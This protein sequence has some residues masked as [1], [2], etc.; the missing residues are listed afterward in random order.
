TGS[1]TLAEVSPGEEAVVRAVRDDDSDGLL[2]VEAAGLL[3]GAR[4]RVVGRTLAPPVLRLEVGEDRREGEEGA[5]GA[6]RPG[7]NLE[8]PLSVARRVYVI[9]PAPGLEETQEVS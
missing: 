9:F 8:V 3:P 5:Q 4:V 2:A 6:D 1:L 7:G